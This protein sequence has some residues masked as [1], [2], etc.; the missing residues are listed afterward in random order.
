MEE[1]VIDASCFNADGFEDF[2]KEIVSGR[3]GDVL[4]EEREGN[5]V[6]DR[7][8]NPYLLDSVILKPSKKTYYGKAKIEVV[9]KDLIEMAAL[10]RDLADIQLSLLCESD[11]HSTCID[12]LISA[13]G[14]REIKKNILKELL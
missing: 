10:E 7:Y 2:Y 3:E 8:N 13:V 5:V 11:D 12:T 6:I 4:I 9:G 14:D 1:M